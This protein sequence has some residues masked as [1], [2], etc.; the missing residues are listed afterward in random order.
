MNFKNRNEYFADF[1]KLLCL[2]LLTSKSPEKSD[3][4]D[5]LVLCMY[6]HMYLPIYLFSVFGCVCTVAR[7]WKSEENLRMSSFASSTWAPGTEFRPSDVQARS[8]PAGPFR[9]DPEIMSFVGETF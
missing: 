6:V 5:F 7:T 1:K 3:T 4:K 8:L 2:S 9:Q